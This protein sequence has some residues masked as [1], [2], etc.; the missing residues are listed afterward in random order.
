MRKRKKQASEFLSLNYPCGWGDRSVL[1][2]LIEVLSK[3]FLPG[4][5]GSVWAIESA[6]ALEVR[7]LFH[8]HQGVAKN[9]LQ[10][11]CSI[12]GSGDFIS[13]LQQGMCHDR[14]LI[15][16][17]VCI[18]MLWSFHL[19]R[20]KKSQTFYFMQFCALE[21]PVSTDCIRTHWKLYSRC[22]D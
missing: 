1:M 12:Q 5:L 4:A 20:S 10:F 17:Q 11:W 2:L 14:S 3:L 13:E 21:V 9:C 22:N 15:G 7:R 6:L 8:S 18:L 19:G 16:V